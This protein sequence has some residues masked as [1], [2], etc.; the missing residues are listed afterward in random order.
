MGI[1]DAAVRALVAQAFFVE[2]DLVECEQGRS[3]GAKAG[4]GE[5]G[6]DGNGSQVVEDSG[7]SRDLSGDSSF[8]NRRPVLQPRR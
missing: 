1:V 5:G 8:H 3:K 7:N 4:G 2:D 6:G